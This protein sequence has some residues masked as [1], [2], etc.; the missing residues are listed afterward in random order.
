MFIQKTCSRLV[1]HPLLRKDHVT[2]NLSD[3]DRSVSIESGSN[4]V[5]GPAALNKENIA[6]CA[7]I[8]ALLLD[9]QKETLS[10]RLTKFFDAGNICLKR[11]DSI[12]L[13]VRIVEISLKLLCRADEETRECIGLRVTE[14]IKKVIKSGGREQILSL[15]ACSFAELENFDEILISIF[16]LDSDWCNPISVFLLDW[17]LQSR[18]LR[19]VEEISDSMVNIGANFRKAII[20]ILYDKKPNQAK[21]GPSSTWKSF[22]S[23]LSRVGLTHSDDISVDLPVRVSIFLRK[24]YMI[25]DIDT[26]F[27]ILSKRYNFLSFISYISS[28]CTVAFSYRGGWL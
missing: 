10:D 9:D 2:L 17:A 23:A 3:F 12:I 26:N 27:Q 24:S 25:C 11:E 6:T 4:P 22:T 19:N 16:L 13:A 21:A 5:L 7:Y 18:H 15:L 28:V 14:F 1:L 8:M 20:K